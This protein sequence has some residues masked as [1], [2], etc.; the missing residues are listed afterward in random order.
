MTK[1]EPQMSSFLHS[2]AIKKKVPISATF[3]LTP[4]CNFSCP[5]C[6]VHRSKTEK[7]TLDAETW[8]NLAKQA[9][10]AGTLFLLL[11]GGEPFL[12]PDFDEIYEEI[13][14]MGFMISINTNGSLLKKHLPILEKYPPTRVNISLYA[15][16]KDD[17]RA[18]C[19]L[20]AFESVRE[21]IFA[22]Q[23][24]GIGVRLNTVFT[25]QNARFAEE[26]VDFSKRH[27][28]FLKS[29]AYCYPQIRLGDECGKN[30]A[31]LSPS[32]AAYFSVQTDKMKLGEEE[33]I[34]KA[35]RLT[36]TVDDSFETESF[37]KIRCRAGR[38]SFWLTWD[39]KMRPC[40]MMTKPET[41]PLEEGLEE[42][43]HDLLRKV[44]QITLPKECSLCKRRNSCPVCAAMCLSETGSFSQ[45][46]QYVCD[47]FEEI[48]NLAED[49]LLTLNLKA[50]NQKFEQKNFEEDMYEC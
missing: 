8:I 23:R 42:A 47:M 4:N 19:G 5:M 24:L 26:I 10:Q 16:N 48:C 35:K 44:E 31:R 30:T 9:R 37:K 28:L 20:D 41:F 32:E 46:P 50:S 7:K 45:K 34:Q 14:K 1:A 49:E 38:C 13:A 36:Q 2:M 43:W 29:T 12:R 40:A 11:T 6:Y 17:Y 21:S 3:E 22:L 33:F 18:F 39:G 25:A 15:A 27:N